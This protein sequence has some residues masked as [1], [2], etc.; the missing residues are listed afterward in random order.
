[1]SIVHVS[2]E[3]IKCDIEGCVRQ[4]KLVD[5]KPIV[6]LHWTRLRWTNPFTEDIMPHIVD[7]CEI[8]SAG[9]VPRV[10]ER[11]A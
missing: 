5:G 3:F 2:E 7:L 6:E 1:M 11:L 8:H 10:K 4:I 9:S